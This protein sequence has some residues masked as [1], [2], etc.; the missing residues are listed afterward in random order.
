MARYEDLTPAEQ[1]EHD[2]AQAAAQ[3]E[4]QAREAQEQAQRNAY[5][6]AFSDI[7][8]SVNSI[9]ALRDKVN[10]IV[11]QLRVITNVSSGGTEV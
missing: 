11:A 5:A 2:A 4:M 8:A 6:A 1:A 7:P 9:P 10:E 3:A